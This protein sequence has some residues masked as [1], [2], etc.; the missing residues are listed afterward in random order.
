M[1]LQLAWLAVMT[2]LAFRL[3]TGAITNDERTDAG[4]Q[5]PSTALLEPVR[6]LGLAGWHTRVN[7]RS[8][9]QNPAREVACGDVMTVNRTSAS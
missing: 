1:V 4:F 2:R 9:T 7:Q 8:Y 5:E 3:V 6:Q